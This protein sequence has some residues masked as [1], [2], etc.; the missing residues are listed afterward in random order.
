MNWY[1]DAF[2]NLGP[3]GMPFHFWTVV[4][5]ILGSMVGSF[6]NVVIWRLPMGQSIVT[7]GSHCPKC[8]AMIPLRNNIPILSWFL[9]RGRGA[10]CG[11]PISFRYPAVEMFTAAMFVAAWLIFGGDAPLQALAVAVFVS[12][13][14]AAS[15]IDFDHVIIP[16]EITYGGIVV[17]FLFSVLVPS[18]HETSSMI[19][20]IRRSG[21]G[22]FVGWGIVYGVLRLG[23]L[24]FG[25][26]IQKIEPGTKV[27]FHETAVIFNEQEIPYEEIYY[28]KSDEIIAEGSKIQISDRCYTKGTIRWSPERLKIEGDSFPSEDQPYL[29]ILADRLVF[30]REAMGLG[31]VKFM[32]AIGA[33]LGWQA[34]LFSLMVSA[35]LGAFTGIALIATGRREWSSRLQYGPFIALAAAIWAYGGSRLWHAYTGF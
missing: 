19:V 14:I 16:D 33:F 23:K 22:I 7:P 4:A 12:G 27:V 30:P 18:L 3:F 25:R 35:F 2:S 28:R 6:L 9:L 17:G 21:V 8:Q 11:E 34:T 29:E 10:C 5:F 24:M 20:A 1:L 31:D 26:D 32:A 15:I 13:L